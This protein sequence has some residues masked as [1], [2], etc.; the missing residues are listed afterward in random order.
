MATPSLPHLNKANLALHSVATREESRYSLNYILVNGVGTVATNGHLLAEVSYP[1]GPDGKAAD[2]PK[3]HVQFL[4]R[5]DAIEAFR[6]CKKGSSAIV[7]EDELLV[8]NRTAESRFK[9]SRYDDDKKDL[10]FPQYERVMPDEEPKAKVR[11]NA[12]LLADLLKIALELHKPNTGHYKG[13]APIDIS[14][15]DEG[16][17]MRLDA[18]SDDGQTLRAVLMPM[19]GDS[20]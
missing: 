12:K 6:A 17:A 3:D 4:G 20:Q 10:V 13:A 11:V 9:F 1:A 15:Y 8:L 7:A 2:V 14:I 18:E 5:D 16:Q 19:K